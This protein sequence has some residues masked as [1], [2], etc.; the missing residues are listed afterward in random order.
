MALPGFLTRNWTL[1]LSAFG[2][3]MLLWTAVRIETPSLSELED[4][5]IRVDVA[6]PQWAL[7]EE[8]TPAGVTVRVRGPSRELWGVSPSIVIPVDNV[9]SNDTTV[10]LERQWV[11]LANRDLTVED[12]QPTVVRLRLESVLRVDLPVALR[13]GGELPSDLA[14][15]RSPAPEPEQLRVLGPESRVLELDSVPT[16]ALDLTTVNGS[17]RQRVQVDTG[18]V[19]GVHV[20][21]PAIEVEL[22][23]VERV[24]R[25][26]GGV[27]IVVPAPGWEET[28][29]MEPREA[30][31]LL[32]GA[33][34]VLEAIGPGS[35]RLVV[36]LSEGRLP[37][38]PGEEAVFPLRAE[39]LP[40]IVRAEMQPS[41][42]T[43]RRLGAAR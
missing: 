22:E 31:V 42:V 17:G 27:P 5:P 16:Q 8:P 11:R 43:V 38:E 23:V 13:L 33:E 29:A 4:V 1:K 37:R 28:W 2:I 30:T 12:I 34:S 9:T 32:S 24:E 40:S 10:M 19:R 3:A 14:L 41:E 36:D 6:D 25:R 18:A 20:Q 26:D 21:P 39:G 7:V 35:F 15:A